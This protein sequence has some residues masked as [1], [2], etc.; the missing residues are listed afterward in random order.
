MIGRET[1]FGCRKPKRRADWH[2]L[3][4]HK[5]LLKSITRN[6]KRLAAKRAAIA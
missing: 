6:E 4:C 5:L 1:C 2:C 3:R